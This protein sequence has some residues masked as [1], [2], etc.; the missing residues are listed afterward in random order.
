VFDACQLGVVLRAVLFV[1][2]VMADRRDVRRFASVL[3]WVLRLAVLT[4]AALPATLAWLMVA[5]SLKRCWARCRAVQVAAG[6]ALGAL[7]GLY[8]CGMLVWPAC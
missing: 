7:A 6:M 1:E 8:G 2:L 5:C 3:D 4:G